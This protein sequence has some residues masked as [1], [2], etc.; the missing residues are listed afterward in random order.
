M[1]ILPF[2][3]SFSLPF[4]DQRSS[5]GI[6]S[7]IFIIYY[8][9]R[10][11][12]DFMVMLDILVIFCGQHSPNNTNHSKSY[13]NVLDQMKLF[14]SEHGSEQ[15]VNDAQLSLHSYKSR[16]VERGPKEA[17]LQFL[18]E[19]RKQVHFL[20]CSGTSTAGTTRATVILQLWKSGTNKLR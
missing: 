17:G 10:H 11:F 12:C 5:P 3:L 20:I 6:I 4:K 2:V 14:L 8:F 13:L 19:Q 1:S 9:E 16:G 7:S 18:L 15:I